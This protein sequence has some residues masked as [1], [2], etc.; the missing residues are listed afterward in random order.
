MATLTDQEKLSYALCKLRMYNKIIRYGLPEE[1][2]NI[3]EIEAGF[4]SPFNS[5]EEIKAKKMLVAASTEA[6]MNNTA[7]PKS[8]R[9]IQALKNK[10][11]ICL[12]FDAVKLDVVPM[13]VPER[14]ELL[15]KNRIAKR[16]EYLR[17]AGRMLKRRGTKMAIGAVGTALATVIVGAPV[18]VPAGI[19]YGVITLVPEKWKKTIKKNVVYW[20]DKVATRVENMVDRF[21][22]TFVGKRLAKATEKIMESKVVT[23]IRKISKPINR[24]I[25]NIGKAVNKGAKRT[26]DFIKSFF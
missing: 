18:S 23:T 11:E 19:I 26:W 9:K 22:K 13:S 6:I 12:A 21:K 20:A 5:D 4:N 25:D 15:K 10:E 2:F 1:C 7:I 3:P 17:R 24:T 16:A 14:E 8:R